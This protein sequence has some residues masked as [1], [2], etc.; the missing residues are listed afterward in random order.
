MPD[1]ETV[2]HERDR[3][4][5]AV[6]RYMLENAALRAYIGQLRSAIT[7]G[8][9]EHDRELRAELARVLRIPIPGAGA[10]PLPRLLGMVLRV[11]PDMPANQ[12]RVEDHNGKVLGTMTIAQ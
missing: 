12:L 9:G 11:D 8:L 1:L 2:Q 3:L 10:K 5:A 4:D 6:E 7:H